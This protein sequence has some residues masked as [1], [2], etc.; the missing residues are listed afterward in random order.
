M[1]P[2]SKTDRS[3]KSGTERL[4][5]ERRTSRRSNS[6]IML[7]AHALWPVKTAQKV[8]EITGYSSRSV[9]NWDAERA[10]IPADA[11]AALLQSEW[12]REFLA[13]V[14]E[15]AQPRW[16]I[17]LKAFFNALD[18]LAMQRATRRKLKEALDADHA[19]EFPH[20]ALLQDE[21]FFGGQPAPTRAPHRAVAAHRKTR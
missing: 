5:G 3:A 16:W 13:A 20:A 17:K 1:E 14:M 10:R 19:F 2:S 4:F 18:V 8:A 15:Q 21:E 12:G 11:L 9:E 7:R 6:V